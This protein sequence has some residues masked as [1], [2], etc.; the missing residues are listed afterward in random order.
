MKFVF[1][2]VSLLG[3]R[4]VFAMIRKSSGRIELFDFNLLTVNREPPNLGDM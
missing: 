2:I 3:V 1:L 4:I